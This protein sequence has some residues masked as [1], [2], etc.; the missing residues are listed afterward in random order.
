MSYDAVKM[1]I[2]MHISVSAHLD[3]DGVTADKECLYLSGS[4]VFVVCV[5]H[6]SCACIAAFIAAGQ[7]IGNGDGCGV[8][9]CH[10]QLLAQVFP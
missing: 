7:V 2:P 1:T 3:L 6:E 9:A 5:L 8:S 10:L 4:K